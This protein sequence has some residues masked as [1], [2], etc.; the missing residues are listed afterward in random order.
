M[1]CY[2]IE[3]TFVPFRVGT[4]AYKKSMDLIYLHKLI[5]QEQMIHL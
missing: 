4:V 2:R 1:L 5:V 3:Q